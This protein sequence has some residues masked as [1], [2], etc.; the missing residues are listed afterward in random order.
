MP[1]TAKLD[2]TGLFLLGKALL[3]YYCCSRYGKTLNV[4]DVALPDDEILPEEYRDAYLHFYDTLGTGL[5]VHF[6][7]PFYRS[8][9]NIH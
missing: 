1:I 2:G 4:P 3:Y 7:Y 6:A 8:F 9:R 5:V